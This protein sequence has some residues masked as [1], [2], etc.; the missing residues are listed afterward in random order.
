LLYL[1]NPALF[2]EKPKKTPT[3]KA[4]TKFV[5]VVSSQS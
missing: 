4:T 1:V 3:N 5:I 2:S